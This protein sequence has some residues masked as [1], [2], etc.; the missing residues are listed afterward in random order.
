MILEIDA[1]TAP[2]SM[3]STD[4]KR[5]ASPLPV[6]AVQDPNAGPDEEDDREF[7]LPGPKKRKLYCTYYSQCA[8]QC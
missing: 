8:S 6:K 7:H 1:N 5:R 4:T 3:P 2:D